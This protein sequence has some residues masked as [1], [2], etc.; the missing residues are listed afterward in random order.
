MQDLNSIGRLRNREIVR[1]A[2]INRRVHP[3]IYF[4]IDAH[5][6]PQQQHPRRHL[7]PGQRCVAVRNLR[8]AAT[9]STSITLAWDPPGGSHPG[10]RRLPYRLVAGSG[11]RRQEEMPTRRPPVTH[12]RTSQLTPSTFSMCGRNQGAHKTKGPMSFIYAS[13]Q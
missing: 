3:S 9:T 6:H 1:L 4:D 7:H 5:C 11:W 12:F 8:V 13:T 10:E 2:A